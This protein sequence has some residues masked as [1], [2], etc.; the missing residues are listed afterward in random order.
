MPCGSS[1]FAMRKRLW[2]ALAAVGI[3]LAFG[4][5][6]AQAASSSH[7]NSGSCSGRVGK[8]GYFYAYTYQYAY[9]DSDNKIS[10]EDHDF[11]FDGFLEGAEDARLLHGKKNKWL[12]YRSGDFDLAVP[13]V[14]DAGL[15][16]RDN[17]DTDNDWIK[18]CD[19]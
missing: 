2:L 19:Y 15:F 13:Y 6:T 3:V 16:V 10:D 11:D 17:R 4:A 9:L 18:L 12:V 1:V 5:A 8:W 7:S 14:D